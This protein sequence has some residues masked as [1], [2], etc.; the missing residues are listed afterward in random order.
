MNVNAEQEVLGA[1]LLD[2]DLMDQVEAELGPDDFMTTAHQTIYKAMLRLYEANQPI[3]IV[4]VTEQL[5]KEQTLDQVGN[6]PYLNQLAS[7]LASTHTIGHYVKV[8][9]EK[10]IARRLLQVAEE[11][12]R[13]AMS[14]DY[15]SAE[16][17]LD[18]TENRIENVRPAKHRGLTPLSDVIT[19]HIMQI[20]ET[21]STNGVLRGLSWGIPKANLLTSGLCPGQLVILAARPGVGKSAMMLKIARSAIAQD[22]PVALFSLE[23]QRDELINRM[24]AAMA[25]VPLTSILRNRLSASDWER[26][27]KAAAVLYE[28]KLNIDETPGI[29]MNYI[30]AQSRRM[31]R[32]YGEIGMVMID[33][34]QLVTVNSDRRELTRA[35]EI[36][37]VTKR[38][39]ELAKELKCPIVMLC[40]LNRDVEKRNTKVPQFSDLRESGNIEQDA[41]II[42]FLHPEP[43]L[44]YTIMRGELPE[45]IGKVDLIIAK[46]R[47][48]ATGKVELAFRRAY[49]EFVNWENRPQ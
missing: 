21:K 42:G 48:G 9:K 38:A 40:Q 15:E 26:I 45:P 46:C 11:I 41:D 6:V 29:T 31:K 30:A 18:F 39:K 34:L 49:Q 32:Q 24:L 3:S 20:E 8:V 17:L 33:Y 44:D 1:I 22:K 12:K 2:G 10:A 7:S 23:M 16:A 36:G 47:N 5:Q 27:T 37:L 4:S 25:E 19:E 13:K 35:Q 28:S 43:E 14:G